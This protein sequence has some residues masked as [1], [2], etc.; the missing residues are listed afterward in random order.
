M[1][2]Y[3]DLVVWQKSMLLV[4]ETYL[5]IEKL[6]A[7]ERFSLADQIRRAVV[8]VPS[9]IAEGYG[10][11]ST[12]DYARFLCIARGSNNELKTQ[13]EICVMLDYFPEEATTTVF[14]LCDEIGK[15]INVMLLKLN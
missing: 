13:I 7:E 3:R 12:R 2:D 15:M 8:S 5:L 9:N 6:P 4:K 11:H 1:R 14:T 10:R